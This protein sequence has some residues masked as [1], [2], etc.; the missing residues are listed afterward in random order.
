MRI[1][2]KILDFFDTA[3]EKK[4]LAECNPFEAQLKHDFKVDTAVRNL[5]KATSTN[6]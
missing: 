4:I 6:T 3:E 5:M 1:Y 2:E